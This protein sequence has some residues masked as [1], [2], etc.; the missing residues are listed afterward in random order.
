VTLGTAARIDVVVI[1]W[2]LVLLAMRRD[3]RFS[4]PAVVYLAFHILVLSTRAWAVLNGAPTVLNTTEAE[5][6]RALNVA[7]LALVSITLGWLTVRSARPQKAHSSARHGANAPRWTP[8]SDRKLRVVAL[9]ALPV[10]LISLVTLARIPGVEGPRSDI[11][12]SY[13]TLAVTWPGLILILL[14]YRYGFRWSLVLPMLTYLSLVSIQGFGRYRLIL[15]AILLVQIWLDGRGR[16]WPSA[17]MLATIAA[18]AIAFFPL[19]SVG[20]LVQHGASVSEIQD[21][22]TTSTRETFAG[23]SSDQTI[24]D[25]LAITLTLTDSHGKLFLGGPYL[26]LLTLPIPRPLWPDKPGLA[27]HI[28]EISTPARP[29]GS[30]GAVTTLPGDLYLNFSYPGIM[31]GM[32][33][34]GRFSGRM[35]LRAY[36]RPYGSVERL[37]YL[38]VSACVIQFARD[39]L[40][41]VPVFLLVHQLP[42]VALI[43]WHRVGNGEQESVRR[44]GPID[45]KE[46]GLSG[47]E[48]SNVSARG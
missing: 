6:T 43:I 37:G 40:V 47:A 18:V 22:V 28:H 15:P 42:L 2:C 17:W 20:D 41:S 35:F 3:L 14:I 21:A 25:D 27:D 12:T 24:L 36:R 26:N 16:K 9:T 4:H 23:R 30:I 5:I 13:Q 34:L 39:G 11:A 33:I 45:L 7:D 46:P 10:G 31:L 8:L 29:L 32:F 44:P 38:L 19:K 48:S 1:L